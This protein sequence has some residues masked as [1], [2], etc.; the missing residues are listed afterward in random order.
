MAVL[1]SYIYYDH[2]IS[3]ESSITNSKVLYRQSSG[4]SLDFLKHGLPWCVLYSGPEGSLLLTD[5]FTQT[6]FA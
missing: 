4:A 3:V 1:N 2:S 5:F 6:D